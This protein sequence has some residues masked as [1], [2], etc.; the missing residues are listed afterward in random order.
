MGQ[1]QEKAN[2]RMLHKG[3]TGYLK[4]N[5]KPTVALGLITIAPC[6]GKGWVLRIRSNP[7]TQ[8]LDQTITSSIFLI[9]EKELFYSQYIKTLGKSPKL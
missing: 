7:S 2:Q 1:I 9:L 4:N 3:H 6:G 5:T 8:A